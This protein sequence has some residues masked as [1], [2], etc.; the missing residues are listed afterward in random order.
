MPR[1][2]VAEAI[3]FL[4]QRCYEHNR[5]KD[6]TMP[7]DWYPEFGK[8][9][10]DEM[11]RRYQDKRMDQYMSDLLWEAGNRAAVEEEN[12]GAESIEEET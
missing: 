12:L 10:V 1:Q 2:T 7:A 11:E 9:M 6:R 5:E 3:D 8:D 4:T